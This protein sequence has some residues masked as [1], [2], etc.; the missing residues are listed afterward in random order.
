MPVWDG[1]LKSKLLGD[2]A[3]PAEMGR[4]MRSVGREET[5]AK[6]R[7][8]I[9]PGINNSDEVVVESQEAVESDPNVRQSNHAFCSALRSPPV[10]DAS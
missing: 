4:R 5:P 7:K 6:P 9:E 10:C 8:G 1:M 3:A 2:R